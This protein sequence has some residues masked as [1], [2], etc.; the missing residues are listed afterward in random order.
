MSKIERIYRAL[1]ASGRPA[2][3]AVQ[4]IGT[5]IATKHLM[6]IEPIVSNGSPEE[7]AIELERCYRE[8]G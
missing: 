4:V 7:D 5:A 2:T 1:I 6:G 8:I 3:F